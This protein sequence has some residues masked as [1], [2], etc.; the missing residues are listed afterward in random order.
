[1]H[2]EVPG[3]AKSEQRCFAHRKMR[4]S[5]AKRIYLKEP[6]AQRRNIHETLWQKRN[7][8]ELL[9]SRRPEMPPHRRDQPS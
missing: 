5:Y 9:Q 6:C 8:A 2:L 3:S 7:I 1:M 4:F